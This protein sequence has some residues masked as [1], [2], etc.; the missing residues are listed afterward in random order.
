MGSP[1]QSFD[2]SV[3]FPPLTG[4]QVRKIREMSQTKIYLNTSEEFDI[5][6]TS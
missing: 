2:K 1:D 3:P 5:L 4:L 6:W